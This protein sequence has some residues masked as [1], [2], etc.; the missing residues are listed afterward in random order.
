M[1]SIL[2]PAYNSDK[3]IR[4][5]I[6]SILNQDYLDFELLIYNDASTDRTLEIIDEFSD[7]RIKVITGENNSG[8]RFARDYLLHLAQGEYIAFV[9]SDDVCLRSKF[10]KQIEFLES[11]E[12]I[13]LAGSSVKYIQEN[14]RS[15]LY[16]FS[17]D[18]YLPEQ[19]KI[20][21]HFNNS[22]AMSTIVFRS[23]LK[24]DISFLNFSYDIAEDY[25]V[26][27]LLS[28]RYNFANLPEKLLCYRIVS[29]SLM[30]RH[31][32][33][34]GKAIALIQEP[35]FLELG[36]SKDLLYYHS[37]FLYSQIKSHLHLLRSIPIYMRFFNYY[38]KNNP[39]LKKVL[40]VNL[41]RK[42]LNYSKYNPTLSFKYFN[43]ISLHLRIFS[44]K[45]S[46]YMFLV[47]IYLMLTSKRKYE[48]G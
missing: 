20:N 5:A 46:V 33:N 38:G 35:I 12:N 25:F 32:E 10:R 9:D 45:Y 17:Y 2:M 37:G 24:S 1:L 8:V 14:G 13:H 26:W 44:L 40:I 18:F 48:N 11:N 43:A 16:P 34:L 31:N 36:L 47:T 15:I 39:N 21:L 23:T 6:E 19:I 27:S 42:C 28:K 29:N 3:F 30:H 4:F 7:S 22:I 41:F